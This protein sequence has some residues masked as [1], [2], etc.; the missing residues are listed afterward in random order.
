MENLCIFF[1]SE[2]RMYYLIGAGLLFI[3]SIIL[4][5]QARKK[6]KLTIQKA[7]EEHEKYIDELTKEK[8]EEYE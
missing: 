7:V 3:I 2:R 1:W 6:E 8:Q 5:I 4:F